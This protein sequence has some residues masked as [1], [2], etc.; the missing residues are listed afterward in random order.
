M[1]E[2]GGGILARGRKERRRFVFLYRYR[3]A[4]VFGERGKGGRRWCWKREASKIFF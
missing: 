1:S 2:R 3:V 4:A